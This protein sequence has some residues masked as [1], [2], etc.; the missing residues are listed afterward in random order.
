MFDCK[1][2]FLIFIV[3]IGASI[4]AMNQDDLA[5]ARWITTRAAELGNE[6][7]DTQFLQE[8]SNELHRNQL[9][10]RGGL[11]VFWG[12]VFHKETKK[13]G[14]AVIKAV[15]FMLSLWWLIKECR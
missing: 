1:T 8:K 13:F 2:L 6:L 9:M 3:A 12:Y 10:V 4:S 14:S 11:S 15:L 5:R 7:D